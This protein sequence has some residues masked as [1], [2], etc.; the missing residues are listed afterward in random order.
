MKLSILSSF[1]YVTSKPLHFSSRRHV[2]DTLPEA[3]IQ[4]NRATFLAL[5]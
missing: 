1:F 5:L 3:V 4:F 2:F